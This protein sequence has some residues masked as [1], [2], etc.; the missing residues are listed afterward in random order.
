MTKLIQPV[1]HHAGE[2]KSRLKVERQKKILQN[3]I[4]RLDAILQRKHHDGEKKDRSPY[5]PTNATEPSYLRATNASRNRSAQADNQPM[6]SI[7]SRVVTI[8]GNPYA[9]QSGRLIGRP[10]STDWSLRSYRSPTSKHQHHTMAS[11]QK[12]KPPIRYIEPISPI[13]TDKSTAS[14]GKDSETLVETSEPVVEDDRDAESDWD[15]DFEDMEQEITYEQRKHLV[16]PSKVGYKILFRTFRLAQ[17]I[18]HNA[19]RKH[20]PNICKRM[21]PNGPHEVRFGYAELE[22]YSVRDSVHEIPGS[23]S[24]FGVGAN[25]YDMISLRNSVCHFGSDAN[26]WDVSRY[27]RYVTDVLELALAVADKPRVRKAIALRREL[28][29]EIKKVL[30]D[31]EKLELL[32]LLP[33][34]Q[35]WKEH[36]VTAFAKYLGST[37]DPELQLPQFRRVA[38]QFGSLN[39]KYY[40]VDYSWLPRRNMQEEWGKELPTWD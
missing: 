36:H 16:I 15:G 2:A 37:E 17:D 39:P 13:S 26:R 31:F 19:A 29:A 33:F 14:Y 8:H 27:I 20:W 3:E 7:K 4:R 6:D 1:A 12:V 23:R 35:P 21:C 5:S 9:F 34:A 10:M 32:A 22:H 25:I 30:N 28:Q 40:P 38:E 18:F 24:M 11:S